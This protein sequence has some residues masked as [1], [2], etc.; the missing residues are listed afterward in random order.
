MSRDQES[1]IDI[2]ESIKL[3]LHYVAPKTYPSELSQYCG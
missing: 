3:I 2:I 1:I